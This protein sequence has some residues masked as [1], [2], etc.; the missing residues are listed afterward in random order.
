MRVQGVQVNLLEMKK[1]ARCEEF[2]LEATGARFR[3]MPREFLTQLERCKSDEARRLLLGVSLRE[4]AS[5]S[6]VTPES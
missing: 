3:R 4:G 2:G 5:G 6:A 1:W